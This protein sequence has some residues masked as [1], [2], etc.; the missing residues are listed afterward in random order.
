MH[1]K[2]A[3]ELL[4]FEG[5]IVV[6]TIYF[7][8]LI[9]AFYGCLQVEID[10]SVDYFITQDAYIYEFYQLNDKYFKQGF[11]TNIFVDDPTIDYASVET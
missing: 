11:Q 9:G 5:R 1:N 4:S 2:L 10:F 8:M 3:P 6:L 7:V